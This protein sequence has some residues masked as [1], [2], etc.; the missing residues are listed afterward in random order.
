MKRMTAL[1]LVLMMCLA[2]CACGAE[3]PVP[4]EAPEETVAPTPEPAFEGTV[5]LFANEDESNT[6]TS[7][8]EFPIC[9]DRSSIYFHFI[10]NAEND[11]KRVTLRIVE[12]KNV[13]VDDNFAS[14]FDIVSDTMKTVNTNAWQSIKLSDVFSSNI[15]LRRITIYLDD[16]DTMLATKTIYTPYDRAIHTKDEYPDEPPAFHDFEE[17]TAEET[18]LY[19]KS[20][21]AIFDYADK[22]SYTSVDLMSA[23]QGET[24][25]YLCVNF[26]PG[27]DMTFFAIS[28]ENTSSYKAGDYTQ[29]IIPEDEGTEEQWVDGCYFYISKM[30]ND[31]MR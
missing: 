19:E 4:T 23:W 2:L 22:Y 20:A 17:L 27:N 11:C 25:L 13:G 28:N 15:Y 14:E 6:E 21:P 7:I 3:E 16:T 30:L 5:E 18:A 10:A 24:A 9:D 31:N 29:N 1:L 8:D 26:R 12:E